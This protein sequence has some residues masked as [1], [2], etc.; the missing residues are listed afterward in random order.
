MEKRKPWDIEEEILL[1]EKSIEAINNGEK[2]DG[3]S[4]RFDLFCRYNLCYKSILICFL[5][6]F[7]DRIIFNYIDLNSIKIE[8]SSM[9]SDELREF[10]TDLTISFKLLGYE[11]KIAII[12]EHKSGYDK[13]LLL[14]MLGYFVNFWKKERR[15]KVSDLTRV[16]PI[17][18]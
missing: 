11:F 1:D 10:W 8:P 5:F 18:I 2:D 9:I 12:I 16:I 7:L 15:N 17:V 3:S 13:F 14:Q 6:N 4:M